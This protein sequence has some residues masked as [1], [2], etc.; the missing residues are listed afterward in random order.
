MS[1]IAFQP[2]IEREPL[3]EIAP[4]AEIPQRNMDVDFD[5]G[6]NIPNDPIDLTPVQLNMWR[7]V[8]AKARGLGI[9][10]HIEIQTAAEL[11]RTIN[12]FH[13]ALADHSMGVGLNAASLAENIPELGVDPKDGLIAGLYHDIGKL[14]VPRRIVTEPG[15]LTREQIKEMGNHSEYG[16]KAAQRLDLGKT[17]G[18]VIGT[19]HKVQERNP[20]GM[21]DSSLTP[22]QRRLRAV[23][24]IS[25]YFDARMSRNDGHAPEEAD[26]ASRLESVAN[27][28]MLTLAKTG[29][30]EL[31]I[32]MFTPKIIK[33]LIDSRA[34]TNF[35]ENRSEAT[36]ALAKL[37]RAPTRHLAQM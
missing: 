12:G 8:E 16:Y 15:R 32:D 3:A 33:S 17:I 23:V 5:F 25:D 34:K 26:V 29:F 24:T 10:E 22:Y 13:S 4:V 14:Q 36:Y 20:V 6:P 31:E 21:D 2:G 18:L 30:N 11:I 37:G 1:T 35:T 7:S 19:H 28:V 9:D 27:H